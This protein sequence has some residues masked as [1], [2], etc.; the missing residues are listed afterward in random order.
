MASPAQL[1]RR[2]SETTGVSLA[3][4]IDL[5]RRL[6]KG[7]LRSKGGRGLHAAHVTPLDAARLQLARATSFAALG[8]NYR[9]GRAVVEADAA[10]AKL[11]TADL[12]AQ[13]VAERAKTMPPAPAVPG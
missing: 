6:V 4:V 12:K 11:P 1:V 5:D 13:F 2:L 8:D 9:A 10:A 3:T 7:G